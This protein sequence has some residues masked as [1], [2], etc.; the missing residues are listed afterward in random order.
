[1]LQVLVKFGV[2]SAIRIY[3]KTL[4]FD[5]GFPR[6]LF[7]QGFCRFRPSCSEYTY[8]AIERFGVIKGVSMALWRVIRCNPWSCGGNDEVPDKEE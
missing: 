7:P 6:F 5:H 8:Q 2:L 4:S 3:Q 1:M